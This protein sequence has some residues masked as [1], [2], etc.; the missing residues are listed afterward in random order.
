MKIIRI[1]KSHT[2]VLNLKKVNKIKSKRIILM[3]RIQHLMIKEIQLKLFKLKQKSFRALRAINQKW[4]KLFLNQLRMLKQKARK[5]IVKNLL[6]PKFLRK[7]HTIIYS[8]I[9][10]S[11]KQRMPQI[12]TSWEEGTR[13]VETSLSHNPC[14]SKLRWQCQTHNLAFTVVVIWTFGTICKLQLEF[15]SKKGRTTWIEDLHT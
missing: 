8:K 12:E 1:F 13:A 2:E 10:R 14:K 15:F 7:F 3:I 4:K 9:I 5:V 6:L 11:D